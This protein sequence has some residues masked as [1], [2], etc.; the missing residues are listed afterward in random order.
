MAAVRQLWRCPICSHEYASPMRVSE[1]LCPRT[2]GIKG[3]PGTGR[4]P[5]VLIEGIPP[6]TKEKKK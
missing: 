4:A 2:H 3:K 6:R 1:V 5:M